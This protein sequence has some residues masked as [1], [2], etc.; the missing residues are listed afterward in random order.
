MGRE[1]RLPEPS[2]VESRDKQEEKY[3]KITDENEK[4]ERDWKRGDIP[5]SSFQVL[6]ISLEGGEE[7]KLKEEK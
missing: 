3:K 6:L 5:S 1:L 4:R 7:Y 2:R